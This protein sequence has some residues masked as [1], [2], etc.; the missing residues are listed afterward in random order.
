MKIR[1]ITINMRFLAKKCVY[2]DMGIGNGLRNTQFHLCIAI[3]MTV[4]KYNILY[5]YLMYST[6]RYSQL[7]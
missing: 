7:E 5:Y 2:L 3:P 4:Y 6:C 1:V